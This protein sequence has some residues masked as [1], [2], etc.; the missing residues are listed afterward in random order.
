MTFDQIITAVKLKHEQLCNA[1]VHTIAT[2]PRVTPSRGI[3]LFSEKEKPLYVGRTNTLRT[4]L[5]QHTRNNENQATFAFLLARHETGRL[6][7]SYR[8]EGSRK[9]LLRNHEFR[10]AFDRARERIRN[11]DVQWVEEVDPTTQAILEIYSAHETEAVYNSF[12]NH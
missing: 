10:D 3:Y 5:Q 1:D 6:Q 4:R 7:A 9:D 12:D 8:P 2:L 11:M